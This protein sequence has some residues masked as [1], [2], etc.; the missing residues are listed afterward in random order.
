MK[1]LSDISRIGVLLPNK[2][3]F[4]AQV[5]MIPF[6]QKLREL[7]PEAVVSAYSPGP[8]AAVLRQLN[9]IDEFSVCGRGLLSFFKTA[10]GVR[11]KKFDVLFTL[12][13]KSERDRLINFFS[14]AKKRI[15]FR[16]M[17]SPLVFDKTFIYEKKMY[18][19]Q[20][21][22]KLLSDY[23]ETSESV[24]VN[25]NASEAWL[26]PAGSSPDKLWPIDNY[27]ALAEKILSQYNKK[28]VFI[29]GPAEESLAEYINSSLKENSQKIELVLSAG[30]DYLMKKVQNCCL[31]VSNDCGPGHITQISG[32]PSL[33]LFGKN[34]NVDEWVNTDMLSEPLI[35]PDGPVSSISVDEVFSKAGKLLTMTAGVV[36]KQ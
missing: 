21:F 32:I 19:A 11:K 17:W 6:F 31:S 24:K 33:V 10:A 22:L 30:I 28:I 16:R 36:D 4:G 5:V 27:I 18:R 29:L 8:D 14:K 23:K 13:R 1:D 15:G 7:F 9:L 3:F 25:N 35:S 20:N 34:A 2:R 12:R 26:I